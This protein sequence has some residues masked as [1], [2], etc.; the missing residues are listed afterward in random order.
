MAKP[1]RTGANRRTSFEAERKKNLRALNYENR[2]VDENGHL[3]S[4]MPN[5]P[6]GTAYGYE[7]FGCRCV[8]LG[9]VRP[10]PANPSGPPIPWGCSQAGVTAAAERRRNRRNAK[11]VT[12]E[13]PQQAPASQRSAARDSALA[14]LDSFLLRFTGPNPE[15]P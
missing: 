9:G 3:V 4:T 12:A 15:R 6:H 14:Q 8:D 7:T 2:K 1:R 13:L 10:D 11:A 5:C